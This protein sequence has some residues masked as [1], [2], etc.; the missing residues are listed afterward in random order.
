[1][2]VHAN[3]KI[4]DGVGVVTFDSP[5]KVNV[6]NQPVMEEIVKIVDEIET[7]SDIQA[8]VL[9]SG[10]PGCFIAGADITMIESCRQLRKPRLSQSPAKIS[11]S[12][13]RRARSQFAAIMGFCLGGGLEVALSCHYRLLKDK[14]GLGL[15]EVMLGVL[16]VEEEP[17]AFTSWLVFLVLWI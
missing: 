16:Q 12:A 11:S 2:G 10:K 6:L 9:I 3:L 15:P 1:M 4:N 17:N 8:A 7:N 13:L 5:G 14:A